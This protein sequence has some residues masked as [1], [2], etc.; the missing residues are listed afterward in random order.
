MSAL[1]S[2][3]ARRWS[4]MPDTSPSRS[5]SWVMITSG[6]GKEFVIGHTLSETGLAGEWGIHSAPGRENTGAR[7]S[8]LYRSGRVAGSI[9]RL[10]FAARS[11]SSTQA[12]RSEEHTSELQSP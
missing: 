6:L 2:F 8:F 9:E 11:Q 5:L 4:K 7:W 12:T 10:E 1:N 3:R